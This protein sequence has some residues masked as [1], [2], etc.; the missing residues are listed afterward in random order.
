MGILGHIHSVESFGTVDGPGIRYILFLQGCGLRCLYC[1]N[2]DTWNPTAGKVLDS[3]KIVAEIAGYRNFIRTGGVTLSGGEPLLQP[4]FA[5]DILNR[6]R[7]QGIHTAL[8]TAGSIPLHIS[9]PVIDA[10]DMLLLDIKSLNDELCRHLTGQNPE[11]TLATLD[12]CERTQKRTWLRYVLV[13]GLTLEKMLLEEL[14]DYVKD[15]SC[16][17]LIELLPF[18]KMGEFK[19]QE[20]NLEYQLENTP[21]PTKEELQMV[22][23]IFDQRGLRY[24]LKE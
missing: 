4:E 10:A 17:E 21:T 9:K 5:A 19:W 12:Y 18:H 16:I 8:D 23:D 20:M 3:E 22:K 2:P 7:Q 13:P 11:H 15:F 14:A 6:C 24:L 1:H